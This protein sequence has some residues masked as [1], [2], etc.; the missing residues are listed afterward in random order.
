M[1]YSRSDEILN[2]DLLQFVPQMP[3][4]QVDY[5]AQLHNA[6]LRE[7]RWSSTHLKAQE[8]PLWQACSGGTPPVP[9]CGGAK[10]SVA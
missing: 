6:S 2:V 5:H 4:R 8:C 7:P 10:A 3:K 9:P 1:E